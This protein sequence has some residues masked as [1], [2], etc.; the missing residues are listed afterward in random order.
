MDPTRPHTDRCP[1]CGWYL[2]APVPPMAPAPACPRCGTTLVGPAADE[3]RATDRAILRLDAER[4]RLLMRRAQLLAHLRPAVPATPTPA[5]GR[6]V[7]APDAAPRT[8]QHL[9]L[10]LGGLLLAVAAIAFT[11]L[12]W[13]HLGIAGRSAVLGALT[14]A[15]AAVPALLLRRSL[16][17]TAEVAACLALVLLL[18]DAYA[19]RRVA[20]P[21]PDGLRYAAVALAVV[22]A[23][24]AGYARLLPRLAL[25]LPLALVLAQLPLCLWAWASGSAYATATALLATAALDTV[26]APSLRRPGPHLTAAVSG[27]ALG[28]CGLLLAGALSATATGTGA[29]LRASGLLL[30]AAAVAGTAALRRTPAAPVAGILAGVAAVSA[31]AAAGGTVRVLVPDDWAAVGYLLCATAALAAAAVLPLRRAVTAGLA[32]GAAAAGAVTV[33]WALPPLTVALL[34]PGDFHGPAAA[35]VVAGLTAATLA[36]AARRPGSRPAAS[37]AVVAAAAAL[38]AV[39]LP[40]MRVAAVASLLALS[41]VALAPVALTTAGVLAVTTIGWV[42]EDGPLTLTV[43]ALL[44]VAYGALFAAAPRTRAVSAACATACA[45]GLAWDGPLVAGWQPHEAAFAVLGVAAA[46]QALAL[47]RTAR[48]FEYPGYAAA[49]LALSLAAGEPAPL[50]LAL[51]CT[52]AVMAAV[53]GLRAERRRLHHVATALFVAALWVRLAA[54][55]VTTPEAY[56]APVGAVALTLGLLAR[57]R[58]PA[59]SS[60]LAYGPGLAVTLLP[61]LVTA[62]GDPGWHRPLLLGA[63]ALAV[64]LLGAARRL[65]APL[66]LGGAVLALDAIRELAPFVVQALDAVPRWVP[67]GV[68][69]L[70]L[71]ALGATYERRLREVRRLR[72]RLLRLH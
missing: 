38:C 39:D 62:W 68:A 4:G 15:A 27:T 63:A 35:P 9:L 57:R 58:D 54:S 50:A 53:A 22:S 47:A 43:L 32:S 72:R 33:L 28:L 60:W 13:G 70:L 17:A 65:A 49:A 11:V 55:G 52:G 48:A 61:S 51:A 45:A 29:A 34:T 16:T 7:A 1:G 42:H 21:G 19:L 37:A 46:A 44:L 67:L 71:V 23:A 20:F 3:L 26:A 8:V 14:V 36:A 5:W 40:L 41:A 56:T 18:L 2:P 6:P 64:T 69:G 12:S 25:P 30:G 31:V 66:L 59:V 10:A 24:W